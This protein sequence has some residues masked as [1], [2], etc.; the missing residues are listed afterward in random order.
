ALETET[1]NLSNYILP[2]HHTLESWGD[3]STYQGIYSLQQPVI[4]PIYDT[5]QAEAM[6]LTWAKADP[7]LYSDIMYHDYL[8]ANW[9]KTVYTESKVSGKFERFWFKSL[10]DGVT[11]NK[12]KAQKVSSFSMGAFMGTTSPKTEAGYTLILKPSYSVADGRFAHNGWMQELPHPVSKVA[13]DNYAAVSLATSQKLDVNN[14][15]MVNVT[16]GET[17]LKLP[18]FVQPGLT[19]DA[20][21]VEMGWGRKLAGPVGSN[22][23]F[24]VN[25]LRTEAAA[26]S[27]WIMSGAK[28]E[29][30]DGYYELASTQE[31]H[32]IDLE[33]IAELIEERELVQDISIEDYKKNPNLI[34]DKRHHVFSITEEWKYEGVKWGMAID[35]NKCIGCS[36][37]TTSCNVENNIP[38]VGK[39]Q[40]ALGREMN[41]LRIDR[42]YSG[43]AEEPKASL[44]PMLCQQCDNAP[45]E[46]VCPVA[47]TVH[48]PDGLNDMSYNRCVGTRY[49]ANNC[50][51]KVRRFNFFNFRD[52]VAN[53]FYQA[54]STEFLHNPEVTV[55]SRGVMEKCTFCVQ[56]ISE[57]KE[58]ARKEQR[59]VDGSRVVVA[60]QEACPANAIVFG[61]I[62]QENGELRQYRDH[63]LGYHVLEETNVKPNVTYI[64]KLRNT[65]TE[66]S[67]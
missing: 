45:C 9:E 56:R 35:M 5:R 7:T 15:D 3:A 30:T 50:P 19:D 23:G 29:K 22:G 51:Y 1:A 36:I 55:R 41:W 27:Q 48:S 47:A 24:D 44:Q 61:D 14:D 28:I 17:T 60:C 38:V 42:Y 8:M 18:V 34:Q 59:D 65:H 63:K 13:W 57:E 54:D 12:V 10:H 20:I 25:P 64:T 4:E 49:C 6:F 32:V 26:L 16:V 33:H 66:E 52:H 31:H 37:C 46:N 53:G 11:V 40:V 62:N 58:L 39:D 67:A 21:V 43:T 2:L